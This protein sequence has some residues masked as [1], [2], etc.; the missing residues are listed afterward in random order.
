MEIKQAIQSSANVIRITNISTGDVY[1]RFD[2]SYDDKVHYG[3][4]RNVHNDGEK[5]IVEAVEYTKS[6]NGVD[7]AIKVIRGEKDYTLFP[8]EPEELNVELESVV[9][10]KQKAIADKG[11]E[12]A[13]LNAEIEEL[14][15]IIS[16][17]VVRS[18][19]A[20]DYKELTQAAYNTKKLEAA[21]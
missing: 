8:A 2:P 3:V 16:G 21:I 17:A 5:A 12:I 14:E 6:W 13:K 7:I 10:S 11:R 20:A 19:K 15:G 4:V 1:K 9:A 18:L